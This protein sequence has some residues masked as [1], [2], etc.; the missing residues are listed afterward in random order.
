MSSKLQKKALKASATFVECKGLDI[1]DSDPGGGCA[2]LV[3]LDDGAL[4]F[5]HVVCSASEDGRF[6]E[7]P[8][9]REA[10]E[11]AA[12]E[13]LREHEDAPADVSVRFDEITL[14]LIGKSRA[15]LRYHTD[16]LGGLA[17]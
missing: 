14:I 7:E 4:V 17:S 1:L 12:A 10:A 11:K 3:A 2:G 15:L 6:P 9:D 5:I 13:W 16:A 8:A